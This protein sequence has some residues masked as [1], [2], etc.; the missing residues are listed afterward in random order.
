MRLSEG[1][2]NK[3]VSKLFRVKRCM[4][5]IGLF[6]DGEEALSSMRATELPKRY[7]LI[8]SDNPAVPA[9]SMIRRIPF[10]DYDRDR[11]GAAVEAAATLLKGPD[12]AGTRLWWDVRP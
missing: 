10:L 1:Y 3:N 12:N 9:D 4:V 8:H 6:P 11:N 5:W 2:E 7:P